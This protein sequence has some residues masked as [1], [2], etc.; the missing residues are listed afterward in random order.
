MREASMCLL[1]IHHFKCNGIYGSAK[2]T[3]TH[4]WKK[5]ITKNKKKHKNFP[6]FFS[7][8][9]K[10]LT[11]P[12]LH[13]RQLPKSQTTSSSCSPSGTP[14][15]EISSSSNLSECQSS[16]P[17]YCC[18]SS[19]TFPFSVSSPSAFRFLLL[20]GNLR[21]YEWFVNLPKLFRIYAPI[22]LNTIIPRELT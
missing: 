18:Y 2:Y 15:F 11:L 17:R 6:L 9:H 14:Q 20:P 4:T 8:F 1:K 7:F 21:T 12:L 16:S 22:F 13:H 5:T 10:P 19:W 3:H